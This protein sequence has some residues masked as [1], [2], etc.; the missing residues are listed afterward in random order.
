MGPLTSKPM[1][2]ASTSLIIAGVRCA[3]V[4]NKQ[5]LKGTDGCLVE[6]AWVP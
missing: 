5:S 2:R 6:G 1:P 3:P 4:I